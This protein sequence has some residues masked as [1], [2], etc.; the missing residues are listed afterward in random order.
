MV[1][2]NAITAYTGNEAFFLKKGK[3]RHQ[4]FHTSFRYHFRE[5]L[6]GL[7][8]LLSWTDGDMKKT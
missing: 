3:V 8:E 1:N 7:V 6:C 4:Y 2:E 5:L